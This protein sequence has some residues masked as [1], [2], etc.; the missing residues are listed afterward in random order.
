MHKLPHCA[1]AP[2]SKQ[3]I[4]QEGYMDI[5]NGGLSVLNPRSKPRCHPLLFPSSSATNSHLPHREEFSPCVIKPSRAD[6]IWLYF[7][8]WIQ[9]IKDKKMWSLTVKVP[10]TN[11]QKQQY[12]VC[13]TDFFVCVCA[14]V[15]VCVCSAPSIW[16]VGMRQREWVRWNLIYCSHL[17][18]SFYR[19]KK[20][21]GGWNDQRS[22]AGP[23]FLSSSLSLE[24]LSA[25]DCCICAWQTG[26]WGALELT[27]DCM[28]LTC[29]I[30]VK[31]RGGR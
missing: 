14:C 30:P 18:M 28:A 26:M 17:F 31:M 19:W 1:F 4:G 12:S 27:L 29:W 3:K 21:K 13:M 15:C 2:R 9:K 22:V 16:I 20:P 23:V 5:D 7:Y 6:R 11:W 10:W 25:V 8:L 24:S